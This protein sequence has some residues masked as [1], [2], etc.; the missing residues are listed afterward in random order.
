MSTKSR[1]T[2]IAVVALLLLAAGVVGVTWYRHTHGSAAH[3]GAEYFCPM[4]PSIVRDKPGE[5]PICGMKLEKR[6]A[7]GAS[8]AAMAASPGE[9]R[10][11]FYRH[12]MDPS[13]HSDKP[14]KDSM[15]MDYVPVYPEDVAPVPAAAVPGHASFTLSPERQQLIGV[16]R[17]RVE[18]RRLEHEVR[19]AGRVAYDPVLYQAIVEYREALRAKDH[20]RDS[21]WAEAQA[22][23]DALVRAA[24][25]KL[26][27][28]GLSDGQILWQAVCGLRGYP[29]DQAVKLSEILAGRGVILKQKLDAAADRCADELVEFFQGAD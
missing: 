9:R 5:C 10:V 24:T 3:A 29:G 22:G 18:R 16:T 15:G 21:S 12:P 1:N 23:A 2:A 11:L 14:A 7:P 4:H 28:R 13:I 17:A 20:L 27:Q 19:V 25:L 26:R 8:P 6:E